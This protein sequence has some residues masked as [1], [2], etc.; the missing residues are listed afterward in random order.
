MMQ[1]A[2]YSAL[3]GS[4]FGAILFT[5]YV[6]QNSEQIPN[7][8]LI[9]AALSSVFFVFVTLLAKNKPTHKTV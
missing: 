1:L 6:G 7:Y 9:L 4:S 8:L 3:L 5:F 2:I